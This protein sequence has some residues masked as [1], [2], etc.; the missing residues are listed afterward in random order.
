M[1]IHLR[2][3]CYAGKYDIPRFKQE[4]KFLFNAQFENN[5][6]VSQTHIGTSDTCGE[7]IIKPNDPSHCMMY[8]RTHMSLAPENLHENVSS[9]MPDNESK[10]SFVIA[11]SSLATG[12]ELL[13]T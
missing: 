5:S 3:N 9:L 6:K 2:I 12:L 11:L 4:Q 8:G 1:N 10:L 13:K 7:G